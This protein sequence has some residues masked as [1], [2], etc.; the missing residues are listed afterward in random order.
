MIVGG[1]GGQ[2]NGVFRKGKGGY[3]RVEDMREGE[4]WEREARGE[5]NGDSDVGGKRWN[6]GR[7]GDKER[8]RERGRGKKRVEGE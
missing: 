5:A 8:R 7:V 3:R 6:E 2:G 4:V 1:E